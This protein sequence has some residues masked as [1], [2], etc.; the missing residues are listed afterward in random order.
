VA[1]NNKPDAEYS[2]GWNS[3]I[4][5][6]INLFPNDSQVQLVNIKPDNDGSSKRRIKI[7]L[8]GYYQMTIDTINSSTDS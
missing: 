4:L 3:S 5:V 6:K 1:S 2:S 7:L 8:R